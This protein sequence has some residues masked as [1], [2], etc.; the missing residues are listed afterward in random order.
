MNCQKKIKIFTP[1]RE[2]VRKCSGS[3]LLSDIQTFFLFLSIHS[4][5]VITTAVSLLS[6]L[7]E[8]YGL[9]LL[10]RWLDD[11]RPDEDDKVMD[12]NVVAARQA[13]DENIETSDAG[14][15]CIFRE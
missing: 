11:H 15:V 7:I 8:E 5:T 6:I 13:T 14:V 9:P 4:P 1:V 12:Y 10:Q 3:Q 2:G